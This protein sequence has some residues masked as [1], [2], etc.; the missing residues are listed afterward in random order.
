MTIRKLTEVYVTDDGKFHPSLEEAQAHEETRIL[1]RLVETA[2]CR[3][4]FHKY[5]EF[6]HLGVPLDRGAYVNHLKE[7]L[8]KAGITFKHNIKEGLK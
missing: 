8:L 5:G 3:A 6:R 2:I 1:G 7:E 4:A